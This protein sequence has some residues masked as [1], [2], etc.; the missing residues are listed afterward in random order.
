[1]TLFSSARESYTYKLQ[2]LQFRAA[3]CRLPAAP[4]CLP[5]IIWGLL[6]CTVDFVNECR[7]QMLISVI[8]FEF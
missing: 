6:L 3:N 5:V 1:M 4:H 2:H 8:A 7:R